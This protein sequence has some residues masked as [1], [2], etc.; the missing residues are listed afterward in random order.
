[1]RSAPINN[2]YAKYLVDPAAHETALFQAATR[3]AINVLQDEDEAQD[4]VLGVWQALPGLAITESFSAWLN[5]RLRWH[6][7]HAFRRADQ[8]KELAASY[9]SFP[10]DEDCEPLGNDDKLAILAFRYESKVKDAGLPDIHAILDPFIRQVANLLLV[11][12]TQ[13]EIAS[14]LC[15]KPAT[16][17]KRL[18][19]FREQDTELRMAA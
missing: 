4:F 16:L 17:R 6:S 9:I 7:L 5:V 3:R 13:D 8:N 18:Q 14:I 1:M 12:H 2:I 10:P 19:R 11:G 15:V